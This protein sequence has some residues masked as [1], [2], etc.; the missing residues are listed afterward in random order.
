MARRNVYLNDD[1]EKLLKRAMFI[2]GSNMSNTVIQ[3]LELYTK[4]QGNVQKTVTREIN[5]GIEETIAKIAPDEL[6]R[7][8]LEK[9]LVKTY[10]VRG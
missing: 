5:K 4:I 6:D 3:A 2:S 10:V 1:G 8:A 7:I 9:N